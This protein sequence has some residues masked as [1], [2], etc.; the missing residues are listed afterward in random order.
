MES[1]FFLCSLELDIQQKNWEKMHNHLRHL[2]KSSIALKNEIRTLQKQSQQHQDDKIHDA[3]MQETP[4]TPWKETQRKHCEH[5]KHR[6]EQMHLEEAML[7]C[8]QVLA[9]LIAEEET[10]EEHAKKKERWS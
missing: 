10:K 5:C 6:E 9:R 8:R 3:T 1:N 7:Q 4:Q 2:Q